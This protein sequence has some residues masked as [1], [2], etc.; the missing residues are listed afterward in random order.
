[1][2]RPDYFSVSYSINPWMDKTTV[3]LSRAQKEWLQLI[4]IYQGLGIKVETIQPIR[5]L[6]DM[7]FSADHALVLDSQ[8]MLSNL[9]FPERQQESKYY[10]EWFKK[11]RLD[12]N[13]LPQNSFFEGS[14]EAI[15]WR[16]ILFIGTGFRTSLDA[17]NQIAQKIDLKVV[18]LKLVNPYFFHLDLCLFP[19]NEEVVFYYP[20]AFDQESI[21]KLKRLVPKLIQFTDKEAY[22]F[23]GNSL[24]TDHHVVLQKD[25]PTFSKK[26]T[27]LGYKT[28]EIDLSEFK[29]AGGGV[30]CL[31]QVIS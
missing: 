9:R 4:R 10:V 5:G 27:S 13:F 19:L 16:G 18:T 31:T 25:N 26:V 22:G 20:Q 3:N 1:M 6:P 23:S 11:Q 21:T 24:V 17:A 12:L 29:K 14:G 28:L 7:V 8:A 2:C 15:V 30:H